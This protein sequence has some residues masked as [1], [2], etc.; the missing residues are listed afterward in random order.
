MTITLGSGQEDL[1]V[2]VQEQERSFRPE[3]QMEGRTRTSLRPGDGRFHN[4]RRLVLNLSSLITSSTRR[5][6]DDFVLL[7]IPY[8]TNCS[9]IP[10]E[11]YRSVC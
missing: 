4:F 10:P 8:P 6:D 11:A 5:F 9:E 7:C 1:G 3:K 2:P